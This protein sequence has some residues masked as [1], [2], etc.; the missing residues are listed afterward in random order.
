MDKRWTI[1]R[2]QEEQPG[3]QRRTSKAGKKG[4][5]KS[6]LKVNI[7]V[8]LQFKKKMNHSEADMQRAK[9]QWFFLCLSIL[10]K[11]MRAQTDCLDPRLELEWNNHVKNKHI[12]VQGYNIPDRVPCGFDSYFAAEFEATNSWV[13]IE[14]SHQ[15]FRTK[16]MRT[17]P[18]LVVWELWWSS[19]TNQAGESLM[20][21]LEPTLLYAC[22]PSRPQRRAGL[23]LSGWSAHL[24]PEFMPLAPSTG[25]VETG[26]SWAW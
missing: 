13:P 23:G 25:A 17:E 12:K 4:N 24:V 19:Q 18:L 14:R 16:Q 8:Q 5:R 6:F 10:A 22:F 20:C 2:K 9:D 26:G 7:Q 21:N 3:Y 15:E 1:R 11:G